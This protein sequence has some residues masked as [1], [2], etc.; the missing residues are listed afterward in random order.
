MECIWN[1]GD[2]LVYL[3]YSMVEVNGCL[4]QPNIGILE[5]EDVSDPSR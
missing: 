1:L 3:P 5:N 4:R 2:L